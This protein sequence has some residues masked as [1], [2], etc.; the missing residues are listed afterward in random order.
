LSHTKPVEPLGETILESESDVKS[1]PDGHVRTD[2]VESD[3]Q[4]DAKDAVVVAAQDDLVAPER[5]GDHEKADGS[6]GVTRRRPLGA[7]TSDAQRAVGGGPETRR[8]NAARRSD[9]E[10]VVG[11]ILKGQ[12]RL[13]ERVGRGGMGIVFRA[14]DLAAPDPHLSTSKVA[15][16]V[17]R[18]ELRNLEAALFDEVARTRPMRQE[19]IVGVYLFEPDDAGGFIVME[20]LTGVPLDRFVTQSHADGLEFDLAWPYIKAMGAALTYAHKQGVIHSD[21]KPSNV[22]V[23]AAS[24][25]VLDFGIARAVRAGGVITAEGD[26]PI[27]LTPEFASCEMLEMQQGDVR[28]DVFCFALVVYV[29]LSGKHPFGGARATVARDGKLP[30]SPIRGLTKRQNAALRK[31]LR[32]D[33]SGRTATIEEVVGEL[34]AAAPGGRAPWIAFGAAVIAAAGSVYVYERTFAPQDS[35]RQFVAN[36]CKNVSIPT[37]SPPA[38]RQDVDA[39]MELGNFYLRRGQDPFDPGI[40][41]ENVSSALGAFQSALSLAPDNCQAAAQGV[42]KVAT[43]YKREARRLYDAHEYRKAEQMAQ[44]ALRIWGD[45]VDMQRLLNEILSQ[46]Q[47][48]G[49]D[50]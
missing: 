37:N 8:G 39:L 48:T 7:G 34:N 28:D 21:F 15:I 25:K 47:P 31:A 16:K 17:L 49:Q 26:K 20:F 19:N 38:D 13:E 2:P 42:L 43:A 18:P 33:R 46:E 44:I 40:L 35:D 6:A 10:P 36:L 5:S 45:S 29:L 32:F 23:V 3:R 50:H 22:F 12:Y 11:D 14:T 27:G 24:A 4:P 1:P 41:S 30:V 9:G